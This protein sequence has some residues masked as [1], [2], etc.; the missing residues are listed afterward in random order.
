[1][2]EKQRLKLD[3]AIDP[4]KLTA[5]E[6]VEALKKP[7]LQPG[8]VE[9]IS[10]RL[11]EARAQAV[12]GKSI[13]QAVWNR[14]AVL[15]ERLVN[16]ITGAKDSLYFGGYASIRELEK[17][18]GTPRN[19]I[20]DGLGALPE[21]DKKKL[22]TNKGCSYW[23]ADRRKLRNPKFN[24]T[25]VGELL[26]LIYSKTVTQ[27]RHERKCQPLRLADPEESSLPSHTHV[28]EDVVRKRQP[29]RDSKKTA[30]RAGEC[31]G[32]TVDVTKHTR[33][34][35]PEQMQDAA[36]KPAKTRKT[37]KGGSRK[38]GGKDT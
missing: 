29:S 5:E 16:A 25:Q 15:E 37:Q 31:T 22:E 38:R 12:L 10:I 1:M 28:A 36:D 19:V 20:S 11:P 24:A 17:M 30:A 18:S 33:K 9:Y 26:K 4:E 21:E 2:P 3:G 14:I 6:L 8:S 27:V 35:E 34:R 23:E 32:R 13:I 7:G